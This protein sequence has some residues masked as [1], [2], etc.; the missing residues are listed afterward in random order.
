MY[1]R[2]RATGGTAEG[3][4]DAVQNLEK[5][6][7]EQDVPMDLSSDDENEQQV[8][9]VTQPSTEG[10]SMRTSSKRKK[11]G[12]STSGSKKSRTQVTGPSVEVQFQQLTTEVGSLVTGLATN[13]TTIA[14]VMANED[15]REQEAKERPTQLANELMN[16]GIPSNDIYRVGPMMLKEK[17][18][19]EFF[20]AL[21]PEA[22]KQYVLD[23][24]SGPSNS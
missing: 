16:L 24:L 3:A 4:T 23:L 10:S 21:P 8:D 14:K 5:E 12:A 15:T 7:D 1:G 17:S 6:V 22:R 9:S 11:M 19:L 13:F 18:L 2:D 20:F